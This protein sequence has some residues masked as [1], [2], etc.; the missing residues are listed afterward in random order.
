PNTYQLKAMSFT[1]Q[2]A[3]TNKMST[4]TYRGAGMPESCSIIERLVDLTAAEFGL[5][6]AEVRRRNLAPKEAFPFTSASGLVYDSGD[7]EKSL[8]K[9]LEIIDYKKIRA[10]QAEARKQ[11][12]Y[13]GI[14]LASYVEVAGVGP[15]SFF[16]GLKVGGWESATV[17]IEPDGK[18]TVLTGSSPHGQGIE[19]SFA[20][21][22][23][24]Q[25]GVDLEDVRVVHGDT[26]R[27]QYG[28]GTFASRSMAVGG[29]ALVGAIG[30]LQDKMKKIASF[31]MEAPPDQLTFAHKAITIGGDL[32]R[33][34]PLQKVV[35]AA[36][37]FRPAIPG[38]EPGLAAQCFFEPPNFCAPFG[39]HAS[40]VEVDL[41]TGRV[42]FLKYAAV[43]DCGTVINPLIVE[44]QVHG[45][46]AQGIGQA[47]CEEVHYDETGQLVSGSLMDYAIPRADLV[48][49]FDVANTVTPTPLNP[50]G[51]KGIGESGCIAG[52]VCVVNAVIDALQPFGVRNIELPLKAERVW[53]AIQEAK[54]A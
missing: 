15:S 11:G 7:Y 36:Y 27:V 5:D 34:I 18:V 44:G 42:K 43:Y 22:A 52:S 17:T 24:D 40:V 31:M 48:P 35:D 9:A 16:P 39:A 8:D 47:L 28:I 53:R 49:R 10:E 21:V 29:A 25:L 14:G 51:A 46:T 23:A 37:Q 32:S 54:K 30:K 33:S 45:G 3:F 4:D 2:L 26:G 50:L 6:P 13:I 20:Q 38:L 1:Q 12:R 41:E 19:T